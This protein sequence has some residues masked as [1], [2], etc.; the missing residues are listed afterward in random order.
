[1]SK[2]VSEISPSI[3]GYYTRLLCTIIFLIYALAFS[4]ESVLFEN[5]QS[6]LES[7]TRTG[8]RTKQGSR[9]SVNAIPVLKVGS[10]NSNEVNFRI[11]FLR[12]P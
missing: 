4:V 10:F 9:I 5:T 12:A 8:I 1:M 7:A 3:L 6:S 2:I 11:D